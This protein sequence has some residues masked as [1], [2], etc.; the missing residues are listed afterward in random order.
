MWPHHNSCK[1]VNVLRFIIK[2][3]LGYCYWIDSLF[4]LTNLLK[5]TFRLSDNLSSSKPNNRFNLRPCFQ[6]CAGS[7]TSNIRIIL[8]ISSWYKPTWWLSIL[9]KNICGASKCFFYFVIPVSSWMYH[10]QHHSYTSFNWSNKKCKRFG[11][12]YLFH[13]SAHFF[14]ELLPNR[15]SRD[16]FSKGWR[17]A[18]FQRC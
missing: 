6:F 2:W 17:C 10:G 16:Q 14:E 9:H 13:Y 5:L 4:H 12:R 7:S 15:E 8:R 18:I 1:P 3:H 11:D